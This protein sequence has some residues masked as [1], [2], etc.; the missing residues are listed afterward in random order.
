AIG[1]GSATGTI[2]D[3]TIANNSCSGTHSGAGINL[4][5]GTLTLTNDTITG[6]ITQNGSYGSG[7]AANG[8]MTIDNCTVAYN[9]T[10]SYGIYSQNTL[11]MY[12]SLFVGNTSW[13]I[14]SLGYN[15]LG[16]TWNVTP[17][18]TDVVCPQGV[19]FTSAGTGGYL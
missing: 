5:F 17:V 1:W 9:G 3:C 11:K 19:S 12:D 4:A 8:N 15:L 18:A 2:A 14:T 13:G 7:I 6:N 16:E 10:K